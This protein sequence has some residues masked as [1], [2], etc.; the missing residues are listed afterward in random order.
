MVGISVGVWFYNAP[1]TTFPTEQVFR[2]EKGTTVRGVSKTLYEQ[3]FIRSRPLFE[4][5]VIFLD[6]KARVQAGDYLFAEPLPIH[7]LAIKIARGERGLDAFKV[8]IP[9]GFTV[10]EISTVV[11]EKYTH[12][13]KTKLETL[14]KPHEGYLFPETYFFSPLVKEEEVVQ[15]MLDMHTLRV[16]ELEREFAISKIPRKDIIIMASII[17]AEAL[18]DEERPYI[19]GILWKRI[20]AGIPMQVDATFAYTL[21]KESKE[22]TVD[23][24]RKD[25]PFNTYTRKGLPPAPI[26]NP[27]LAS[28]K[29][30]LKPT[31]STYW[32]YLHGTDGKIHYAVTHDEHVNNKRLYID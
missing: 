2:I 23:D 1:P 10:K 32:Y 22:L 14:L 17:E 15:A 3:G 16:R 13:D 24:L 29:A 25:D 12:L 9:E 8:T 6:P 19:S 27:G 31:L 18:T 20:N 7:D 28:I 5:F 21:G 30:A 11:T 4:F 26:G